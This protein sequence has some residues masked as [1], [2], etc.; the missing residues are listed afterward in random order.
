MIGFIFEK[1]PLCCF[2]SKKIM[3]GKKWGEYRLANSG[4][5][6]V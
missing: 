3:W 6:L 5:E 1:N 4:D 2:V